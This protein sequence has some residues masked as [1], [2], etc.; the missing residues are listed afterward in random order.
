MESKEFTL[1]QLKKT[2]RQLGL[3]QRGNKIELMKRLYE[4]DPSGQ[5]KDVARAACEEETEQPQLRSRS[6]SHSTSEI[7]NED[8]R[9]GER[10][11]HVQRTPLPDAESE[12]EDFRETRMILDMDVEAVRRERDLL[13]REIEL[14]R[15]ERNHAIRTE[16]SAERHC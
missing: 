3:S 10:S 4:Q 12:R 13:R 11:R 8:E 1:I 2:L 9:S 6:E 5:W 7:A 15:L 16:R 14:L